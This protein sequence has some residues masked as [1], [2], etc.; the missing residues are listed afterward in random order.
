MNEIRRRDRNAEQIALARAIVDR[1]RHE[2]P[3]FI[4]GFDIR[5]GPS[6]RE[7]ALFVVY[8]TRDEEDRL[9]R[10][11]LERRARE[12]RRLDD[13]VLPELTAALDD[14]YPYSML[15]PERDKDRFPY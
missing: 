8:W 1:H 9:D 14:L 15:V 12:Y 10:S 6:S 13:S 4:S 2:L 11:E 3:D 7:P 5:L